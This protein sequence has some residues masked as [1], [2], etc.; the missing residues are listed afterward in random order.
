[1]LLSGNF[2]YLYFTIPYFVTERSF[3]ILVKTLL[4]LTIMGK[5]LLAV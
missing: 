2:A 5:P 1:M 3:V 4:Y